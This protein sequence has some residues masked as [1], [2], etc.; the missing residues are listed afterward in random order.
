MGGCIL[1]KEKIVCNA[2]FPNLSFWIS[3]AV[4][5]MSFRMNSNLLPIRNDY[6]DLKIKIVKLSFFWYNY[7]QY[8]YRM[9]FFKF[10]Q[11][12]LLQRG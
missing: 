12:H 7:M 11:V 9:T 2:R 3:I 8:Y 1:K 10:Y 5:T 6:E 4:V